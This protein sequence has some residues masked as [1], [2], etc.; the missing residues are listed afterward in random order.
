MHD[1][2]VTDQ[3]AVGRAFARAVGTGDGDGLRAVLA[4][5]VSF[6]AVTPSRSWDFD[7][8]GEAIDTMLGRW[9]GGDKHVEEVESVVSEMVGDVVRVGD[10]VRAETPDGQALVEQQ[11]YLDVDEG[12][13]RGV[14][15]VCSGY[16]PIGR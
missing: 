14:R 8:A 2:L 9:F 12:R 5:D 1:L 13:I 11:A 3:T 4:P 7:E 16:R 15:L 6:R 10:R